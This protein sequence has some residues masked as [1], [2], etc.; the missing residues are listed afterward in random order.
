MQQLLE[1]TIELWPRAGPEPTGEYGQKVAEV[2][3]V[4]DR[5][6]VKASEVA[7]QAQSL[8]DELVERR[9]EGNDN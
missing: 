5:I 9:N 7:Y 4:L 3:E 6:A 8:R 2:V 1:Q